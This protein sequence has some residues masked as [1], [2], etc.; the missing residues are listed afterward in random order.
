MVEGHVS[1]GILDAKSVGV[2][3]HDRG[4]I[5]GDEGVPA[6]ALRALHRLQQDAGSVAGDRREQAD[7]RGDVGEQ[8]RPEGDDRPVAREGVERGS[9]R[10]D[11]EVRSQRAL[12]VV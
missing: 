3:H 1:Y 5:A 8:L 6:P 10:S 12:L 7:R 11:T 4:R 9:V 2:E